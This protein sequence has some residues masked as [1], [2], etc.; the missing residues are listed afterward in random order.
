MSTLGEDFPKE[1]ERCRELLEQYRQI[2]PAGAFGSIMIEKTLQDADKAAISGDLV[3]M[4]A[5]YKRM[6]ECE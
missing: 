5:A 4:I 3:W 2:G 6:K 1:Q